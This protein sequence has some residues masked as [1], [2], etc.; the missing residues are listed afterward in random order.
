MQKNTIWYAAAGALVLLGAIALFVSW[1]ANHRP[2]GPGPAAESTALTPPPGIVNPVPVASGLTTEPLPPLE[3]S[4]KP[5]HDSLADLLGAKSV[6]EL[7][8]ADMLV[9]HIVVTVDNLPRK[10]LAVELRPT[11]NLPGSFA[12]SGD[13]QSATIDS[14]NYQRYA[15]YV[16]LLQALNTQQFTTQYFH[17]YPLFQQAYESLGYPN[18]YF[19]D[20]LVATIDD[21]LAAP[22]VRGPVALVR[23]NVM[24][25]YADPKIE[26]LSAGQKLMVRMGPDNEAVVKAK[27]RELRAAVAA[28]T[29]T[30]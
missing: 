30:E 17:Y 8:R 7:I 19:N 4:D 20:R 24:Y 25:Q 10:H 1:R 6:D 29:K 18:G 23:P 15:P 28:H 16:H 21:A 13:D 11:K 22:D 12:V 3:T 26:A 2:A 5:M 14:S 27:L 9:R